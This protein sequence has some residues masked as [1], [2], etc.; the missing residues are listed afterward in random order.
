LDQTQILQPYH[1]CLLGHIGKTA[2]VLNHA[3]NFRPIFNTGIKAD[4]AAKGAFNIIKNQRPGTIAFM[5]RT[6]NCS[7]GH[8]QARRKIIRLPFNFLFR[9]FNPAKNEGVIRP[10]SAGPVDVF[11]VQGPMPGFVS[12]GET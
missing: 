2:G 11:P 3:G 4:G 9:I 5:K 10:L 6:F 1:H 8:Q 12:E 7:P